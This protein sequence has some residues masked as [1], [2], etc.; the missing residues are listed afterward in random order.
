MA[1]DALRHHALKGASTNRLACLLR[2]WMWADQAKERFEHQLA[3]GWEYDADPQADHLFGAYHHW[4]ALLCGLGEAALE[5]AMLSEEQLR[6]LDSDLAACLPGLRASRQLL[7]T[8][9]ASREDCPRIVDLLR[10][11]ESV[12]RLRRVHAAFGDALREEHMSR[13]FDLLDAQER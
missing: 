11:S 5:R 2:H 9:P 6:D 7:V 4:C 12:G 3:I 8:I 13:D 1:L 10:G